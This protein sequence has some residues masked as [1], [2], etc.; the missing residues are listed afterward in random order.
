[1]HVS[2]REH[3][4]HVCTRPENVECVFESAGGP[5]FMRQSFVRAD[6]ICEPF[7]FCFAE[8]GFVGITVMPCFSE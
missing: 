8:A 2:V 1:M 6:E 3:R 4:P 5:I 7:K